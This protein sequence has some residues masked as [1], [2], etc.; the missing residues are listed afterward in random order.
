M[1]PYQTTAALNV[2]LCFIRRHRMMSVMRFAVLVGLVTLVAASRPGQ[3]PCIECRD[4][5]TNNCQRVCQRS[6]QPAGVNIETCKRIGREI[7]GKIGVDAC[8]TTKKYCGGGRS[9]G[10]SQRKK[11]SLQQCQNIAFGTCQNRAREAALLQGGCMFAFNGFQQCNRQQWAGFFNPEVDELC[12]NAVAA[13]IP[14]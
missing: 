1:H 14:N 2:L 13:R 6:C 12:A 8:G 11:V 7:G 5:R 4:C 9:F 3:G 10:G